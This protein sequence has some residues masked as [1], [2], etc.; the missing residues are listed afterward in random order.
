MAAPILSPV[1]TTSVSILPSTGSLDYVNDGCPFKIYSS[2]TSPLYSTEFLSGAVEQVSYVYN[3][4]GGHVLDIEIVPYSVYSTY[5]EAVLAYSEIL[6]FHQAKN[7]LGSLLGSAT[8]T[9]DHDGNISGSLSGS[10]YET[11]YP[12]FKF[13]YAERIAAATG[14]AVGVGGLVPVYSG[15]IVLTGSI[16]DYDL[17][18][19]MSSSSN[20]SG[21]IGDKRIKIHKVFYKTP[22]S[23]WRFFSLFGSGPNA[24]YGD[25]GGFFGGGYGQYSDATTFEII[26]VWENKLRARAYEDAINV[27][28]SHFSYELRNNKLRIYPMP[29]DTSNGYSPTQI[30][31]EFSIDN[32]VYD[33]LNPGQRSDVEG[34]NNINNV[35]YENL[36][37]GTINS[38][39]KNWIRR[40]SLALCKE[41]LGQVRTKFG[42]LPIPNASVTLNGDAL[43]AQAKEEQAALKE[44][45]QK[46]L[47][48]VTYA[49]IAKR[50][51]EMAESA[52][53]VLNS[54]PTLIFVG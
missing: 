20:Y 11:K 1:S 50:E 22:N 36:P 35:P 37:Y 15:S 26:P 31:F 3:R 6:N 41:I 33:D 34:V 25:G 13:G 28:C 4:L 17:Q 45:L 43:L 30:W 44:E 18:A 12:R 24:V 7:A 21:S 19:A 16:Q 48:A 5:E 14:E 53:K 27:R 51:S 47:E 46:T 23:A 38:M 10:H 40:F 9:F 39:G 29:P 2:T 42:T 32:D 54:I 8:G 52:N 49:E